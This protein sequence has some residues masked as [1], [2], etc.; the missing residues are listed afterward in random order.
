MV[1]LLCAFVVGSILVTISTGAQAQPVAATPNKGPV[2]LSGTV[3]Y[4]SSYTVTGPC[5]GCRT[6]ED[7]SVTMA[8]A[9]AATEGEA[10]NPGPNWDNPDVEGCAQAASPRQQMFLG[11]TN[12]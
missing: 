11:V 1:V 6:S 5:S 4:A 3:S 9:G 12:S 7:L 2:A 8:V 10:A